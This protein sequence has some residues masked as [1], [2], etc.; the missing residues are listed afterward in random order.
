VRLPYAYSLGILRRD[1]PTARVMAT[2][3]F[4]LGATPDA[5]DRHRRLV[6]G[7]LGD[8]AAKKVRFMPIPVNFHFGF[9]PGETKHDEVIAVGRWE[10]TQK[11][12]PLLMQVME[13][14][15]ARRS[16]TRFR[17]F[18][19]TPDE[20]YEWHAKLAPDLRSSIVLEGIVPNQVVA[21]ASRR[22]RAM[23]VSAVFEGC[24]NSSAEAIC[25]G[26]CIVGVDSPFLCA[27]KWHASHGSG[28]MA[29]DAH[30]E[31]LTDALCSELEAWDRGERD[32]VEISRYWR[33]QLQPDRVAAAILNLYG[34][35]AP[36]LE[37]AL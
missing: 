35:K 7:L 16:G 18:G 12:A 25:S 23:L 36:R 2:G 14:A 19:K 3:D 37:A 9:E 34:L 27:L 24:H 22:A 31:S 30:P 8:E 29:P 13:R 21:E 1:L 33:E 28:T 15:A 32:P 20:M 17:V 6:A 5:T 10:S 26:C 11:R 4:F